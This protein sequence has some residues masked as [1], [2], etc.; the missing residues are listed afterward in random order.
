MGSGFFS[1][2]SHGHKA[3]QRRREENRRNDSADLYIGR[4]TDDARRCLALAEEALANGDSRTAQ[5]F[6][7]DGQAEANLAADIRIARLMG[8]W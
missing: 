4:A 8:R 1:N 7:L 2:M 5:K 3:R 6:A